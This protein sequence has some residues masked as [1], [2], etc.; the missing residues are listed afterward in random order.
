[1]EILEKADPKNVPNLSGLIASEAMMNRGAMNPET[2]RLHTE[3]VAVGE[4]RGPEGIKE[5]VSLSMQL[6][7]M[8]ADEKG[9]EHRQVWKMR[10]RF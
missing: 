2:L 3:M 6:V 7:N 4:D 9:V 1:M 5:V 10:S 8:L